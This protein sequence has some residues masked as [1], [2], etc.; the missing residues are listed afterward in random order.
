MHCESARVAHSRAPFY[1]I[2]GRSAGQVCDTLNEYMAT[3]KKL[4]QLLC[5]AGLLTPAQLQQILAAQVVNGGRLGTTAVEMELL[6]INAVSQWLADQLQ[7]PE[8]TQQALSSPMADAVKLVPADICA[9]YT[10]VPMAIE[11]QTLHIA[12]RDPH[13]VELLEDLRYRSGLIIK[14]YVAPEL[15]LYYILEKY[16]GIARH[17]RFR[18]VP[19]QQRP[20]PPASG[21]I[22]RSYLEPTV[23]PAEAF[24]S[25]GETGPLP[26]VVDN[27][28]LVYLDAVPRSHADDDFELTIDETEPESSTSEHAGRWTHVDQAIQAIETATTRV[29]LATALARPCLPQAA[30]SVLFLCRGNMAVGIE[31]WAHGAAQPP[32]INE[33]V[34]SL[35]PNSTLQRAFKT[36]ETVV[37]DHSDP[38]QQLIANYL[39][40]QPPRHC[41]VAPICVESEVVQL[42]CLQS[43]GTPFDQRAAT[44]LQRVCKA[45]AFSYQRLIGEAAAPDA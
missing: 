38:F 42:L 25:S 39:Q 45:A 27:V 28:E 5:E 14:P 37:A 15:R 26:L 40:V 10:L 33:L 13:N 8:A 21:E 19:T 16:F 11:G 22:A 35:V 3:S 6:S 17:A 44:E 2:A 29:D 24:S 18:R 30:L 41:C 9:R 34:I 7:V 36:N 32:G 20:A 23:G 4:G 12:M 31:A 1:H 43:H